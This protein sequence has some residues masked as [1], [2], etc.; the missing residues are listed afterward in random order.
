MALF[1]TSK[2]FKVI[3]KMVYNTTTEGAILLNCGIGSIILENSFLFL[4][5]RQ[6]SKIMDY[7]EN[8]SYQRCRF[9]FKKKTV[10]QMHRD[11]LSGLTQEGRMVLLPGQCVNRKAICQ[12][13]LQKDSL[14]FFKWFCDLR[15]TTVISDR[16]PTSWFSIPFVFW[17]NEIQIQCPARFTPVPDKFIQSIVLFLTAVYHMF[18]GS[19]Q[20]MQLFS[21]A[22]CLSTLWTVNLAD[23]ANSVT[24]SMF[25]AF[26]QFRFNVILSSWPSQLAI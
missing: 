8:Y 15:T 4:K 1:V 16:R 13:R 7:L 12:V 20:V 18:P 10:L 26:F 17:S 25:C 9:F 2:G 11:I 22:V 24:G 6:V 21:P 14:I 19:L 3:L 23:M 5:S